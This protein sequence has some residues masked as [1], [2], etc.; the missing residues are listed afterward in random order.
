MIVNDDKNNSNINAN[1]NN[2]NDI[3]RSWVDYVMLLLILLW[4][5]KTDHKTEHTNNLNKKVNVIFFG[6]EAKLYFLI[7]NIHFSF[8]C[9]FVINS[10]APP[11]PPFPVL[12]FPECGRG[13]VCM[14][15]GHYLIPEKVC[16]ETLMVHKSY[17]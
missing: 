9:I 4:Y 11:H 13:R 2:K 8:L 14:L 15:C 6:L 7:P 10:F 5:Y 1:D 17:P 12:P 3:D 16:V